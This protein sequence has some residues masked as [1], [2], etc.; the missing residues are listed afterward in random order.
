MTLLFFSFLFLRDR[1]RPVPRLERVLERVIRR[2]AKIVP[3]KIIHDDRTLFA[4]GVGSGRATTL[5]VRFLSYA[6]LGVKRAAG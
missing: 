4:E 1:R 6:V 5:H 2:L 3:S